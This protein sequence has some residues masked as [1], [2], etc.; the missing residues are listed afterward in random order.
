MILGELE[1]GKVYYHE[2]F[3]AFFLFLG[4]EKFSFCGL[5]LKFLWLTGAKKGKITT[6]STFNSG[7]HCNFIKEWIP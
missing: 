3:K 2:I 7:E 1:F 6:S 4:K 5:C